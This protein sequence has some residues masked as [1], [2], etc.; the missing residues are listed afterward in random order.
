MN[1][2]DDPGK[3]EAEHVAPPATT[4]PSLRP[5]VLPW[6]VLACTLIST[7]S[8]AYYVWSKDQLRADSAA[9]EAAQSA[10]DRIQSRLDSYV[11]L[12]RG[13]AGFVSNIL[14]EGAN[15]VPAHQVNFATYVE[16]MEL[17]THYPGIQ[18]IGFALRLPREERT[19]FENAM[20]R[21]GNATFRVWS[22]VPRDER[23]DN[24]TGDTFP[25]VYLE[26]PDERNHAVIGFDMYSERAR[27]AAMARAADD[28]TPAASAPVSLKQDLQP[29]GRKNGFLIY[30]PVYYTGT[31]P[32][33]GPERSTELAG[34]VYAAFRASDLVD[35]LFRGI[36][37]PIDFSVYDGTMLLDRTEADDSMAATSVDAAKDTAPW[38]VKR[39]INVFGRRWT[40]AFRPHVQPELSFRP[41]VVPGVLITGSALALLLFLLTHSEGRARLQA[42][43]TATKLRASQQALENANASLRE[44]ESLLRTF[45]DANIVGMFVGDVSGRIH[46][47]N[48][49]FLKLVG[50]TQADVSSGALDWKRVTAPQYLAELDAGMEEARRTGRN[51]PY[52]KEFVRRDG[53]RVP[54]LMGRAYLGGADDRFVA[55]VLDLTER[56]RAEISLRKSEDQLRLVTDSLP[57]LIAYFD[58]SEIYRFC[59][60]FYQQWFGL[61]GESIIGRTIRSMIGDNAYAQRK[62]F[63]RA[64]F[65]GQVVRFHGPTP[66]QDGLVRETEVVYVPDRAPDGTVR[67]I[68]SLVTDVTEQRRTEQQLRRYA[69]LFQHAELGL[70]VTGPDGISLEMSN[71]AFARICGLAPGDV[72]GK[73]LLDVFAPEYR[74]EVPSHV[75]IAQ[76]RGH[77]TFESIF[78]RPDGARFP[79]EVDVTAVKSPDASSEAVYHIFSF[80]D[81]TERE[82]TEAELRYQLH[83][84][85]TI[86]TNAADSLFMMDSQGRVTFMNPAAEA[87]LGF[88]PDDVLGR[89]LGQLVRPDGAGAGPLEE[90]FQTGRTLRDH[91]DVFHCKNGST[92]HVLCTIAPIHTGDMISGAV[93]VVHDITDRKRAEQERERLLAAERQAR[94]EAESL[95]REAETANRSKDE[96]LATLSH[97]LRTPLN[98]M[99]GWA[100]LLKVGNLPH[101]EFTQ[102]LDTIE[103]NARVQSQLIEDLLDLSRIISGKLRIDVGPVDLPAVIAATLDTIRPAA[104]AKGIQLVPVIDSHAGAIRGDANRLQQVVWNLLSNAIKFTPRGGRVEI[105]LTSA[106][107]NTVEIS[108]SD[109]GQGIAQEFLPHVFDRLRQADA[110]ITRKHGGLGLGLAI[111]RH[112]V[113]LHGGTVSARSP[114]IDQGA[115]FTVRLPV[116]ATEHQPEHAARPRSTS[117]APHVSQMPSL[118]GSRVLVVDDEPDARDLIARILRQCGADVAVASSVKEALATMETFRPDLLLSDIGMPDEDGYSLIRRVRALPDVQLAGVPAIA[119]TALARKEDA[120]RAVA[121]GFQQHVAK[122]VEPAELAG[123]VSELLAVPRHSATEVGANG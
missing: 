34:F 54:V 99:L 120:A 100:Q 93:L 41:V 71:P 73:S 118:A 61:P 26:P 76:E 109:T 98:A 24:P 5:R 9:R 103:R 25:V 107:D 69:D 92:V 111:V 37:A 63:L 94:A 40:L 2:D 88:S 74:T 8:V 1:A 51:E 114:G 116:S 97:E 106:G 44:S 45:T 68:V 96:F 84:T 62:P 67:G 32:A 80:S 30:L 22:E 115:T 38:D 10:R 83:L 112:L 53:A 57:V 39:V 123:A 82:R 6:V 4:P 87:F 56:K 43:Y 46:R 23:I 7:F 113:E 72:T 49:A 104:D 11:S 122:P 117:D 36:D 13:S 102:G 50:Y 33:P 55:F 70:V 29:G 31:P 64:A 108:V 59:N 91:E 28:A 119:L 86:T 77:H 65:G 110:S 101:D 60:R 16:R 35:D 79:V 47:A 27:H 66:H 3:T 19:G 90:V 85:N 15:R 14:S 95:T 105:F 58:A 20:R 48:D 75:R 21:T 78:Q 89:P 12:L 18:G 42:E 81:I 17:R 121:E 52:E